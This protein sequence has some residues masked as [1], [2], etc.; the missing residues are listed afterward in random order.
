MLNT[1]QRGLRYRRSSY[2]LSSATIT[3]ASRDRVGFRVERRDVD[4][5][6]QQAGAREVAQELVAEAGALGG[7]FDQPGN[8][9]DDEAAVLPTRTTP[10]LGCSVVK[11]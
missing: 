8:V 10:R 6:Q 7:A 4:D 5:V 1:S 9:G 11:G 2:F 3:R